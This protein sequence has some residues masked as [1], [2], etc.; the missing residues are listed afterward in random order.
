MKTA[1][2]TDQSHLHCIGGLNKK[3]EKPLRH[4]QKLATSDNKFKVRFYE[5]A[6]VFRK[7]FALKIKHGKIKNI[8]GRGMG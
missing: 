2:Y 1:F 5:S 8:M 4:N 7:V 6:K 3:A